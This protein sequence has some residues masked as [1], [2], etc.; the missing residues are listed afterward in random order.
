M[1]PTRDE[2]VHW[3]AQ[4]LE[5]TGQTPSAL[6]RHAG[7]ATTTLTRFLNDRDAPM[8]SLRSI[9]KIAHVSGMQP[10]GLPV[11]TGQPRG[12]AEAEAEPYAASDDR[13]DRAVAALINGRN[14]TDPWML[15]TRAI[16]ARG[17]LPGDIVIVDLNR[18]PEKNDIVCAQVYQWNAGKAE[19]IW[20]L[21]DP[22]YLIAAC[23]DPALAEQLQR[24]LL[25]DNDRVL[26]KGVV[27]SCLRAPL[28]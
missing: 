8:L 24:P 4:A 1:E 27:T 22:P 26:I 7:L 2:I 13:I 9:A 6:A 12:L 20:R 14:A 23:F 18:K 15:K 19:T 21:F 10:A 16:E 25:V 11:S 28:H 17:Y 3:L 5:K